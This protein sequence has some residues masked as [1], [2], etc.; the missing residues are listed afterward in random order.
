MS[1]YKLLLLFFISMQFRTNDYYYS[2]DEGQS[3][4]QVCTQTDTISLWVQTTTQLN[5][6]YLSLSHYS[7]WLSSAKFKI[8]ASSHQIILRRWC[9]HQGFLLQSHEI[10]ILNWKR[11]TELPKISKEHSDWTWLIWNWGIIR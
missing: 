2:I 4:H 9:T 10:G 6:S 3:Q 11:R 5:R 1:N 8:L 7:S